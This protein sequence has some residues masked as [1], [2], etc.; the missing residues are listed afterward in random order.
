MMVR[1]VLESV[2]VPAVLNK[3]RSRGGLISIKIPLLQDGGTSLV[4][5]LRAGFHQHSWSQRRELL[6]IISLTWM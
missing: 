1:G 5:I 2:E 4:I 3:C 6:R